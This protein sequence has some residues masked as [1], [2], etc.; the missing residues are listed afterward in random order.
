MSMQH[1]LWIERQ[2]MSQLTGAIELIRILYLLKNL[3]LIPEL[4]VDK[5]SPVRKQ[6][7]LLKTII[8]VWAYSVLCLRGAPNVY[9]QPWSSPETQSLLARTWTKLEA[10][11]SRF[12]RPWLAAAT[13]AS[14]PGL[15]VPPPPSCGWLTTPGRDVSFKVR[16]ALDK[17]KHRGDSYLFGFLVW[18]D[19]A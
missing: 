12:K 5:I 10:F 18:G 2:W 4:C 6:Q 11:L 1:P 3:N 14:Y 13:T 7:A 9:C 8:R 15:P 16:L 17:R 19:L